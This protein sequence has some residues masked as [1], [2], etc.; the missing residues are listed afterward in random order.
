MNGFLQR[1]AMSTRNPTS[2]IHPIVGS[3]YSSARR[4]QPTESAYKSEQLPRDGEERNIQ[5]AERLAPPLIAKRV[6]DAAGIE[7]IRSQL[8]MPPAADLR[9]WI[10]KVE[11]ADSS[12]AA[13]PPHWMP[14]TSVTNPQIREDQLELTDRTLNSVI[15]RL[16]APVRTPEER[17]PEPV[18][19]TT[20]EMDQSHSVSEDRG[21][22]SMTGSFNQACR[23][24]APIP[25]GTQIGRKREAYVSDRLEASRKGPDE[26]QIHIGR[27][28]VTAVPPA[29][30]AAPSPKPRHLAPSLDEYL[31]R[32]GRGTQ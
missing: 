28:E 19:H 7:E 27:I 17:A 25:L 2:S 12:P 6:H 9:P 11:G 13:Q 21:S 15:E 29:P 20:L 8:L 31:Q 3:F 14:P 32:R 18:T 4:D 30:V 1:L 26:I 5:R 16:L 10:G 22:E 24:L 23:N